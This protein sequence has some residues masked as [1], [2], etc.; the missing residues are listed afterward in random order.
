MQGA[1]REVDGGVG[2]GQGVEHHEVVDDA[3]EADCGDRDTGGAEFVG[4]VGLALVAQDVGLAGDDE[5]RGQA[6]SCSVVARR[7]GPRAPAPPV[8]RRGRR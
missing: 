8:S 4:G 5:C 2:A 1:D 3:L 6:G 7:C